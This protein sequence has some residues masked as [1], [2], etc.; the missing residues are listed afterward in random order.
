M[1]TGWALGSCRGMH[2][3]TFFQVEP[4]LGLIGVAYLVQVADLLHQ[5]FVGLGGHFPAELL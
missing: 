3:P 5:R 4:G 1:V 2:Q